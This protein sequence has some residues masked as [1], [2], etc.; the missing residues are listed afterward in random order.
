MRVSRAD[1]VRVGM[2]LYSSMIF[3]GLLRDGV[4]PAMARKV[5]VTVRTT[6]GAAVRMRLVSTN[7]ALAVPLPK[8]TRYRPRVFTPAEVN[9]FLAAAASDR[10]DALYLL[11][12]DS[13]CRQSEL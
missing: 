12:I 10:F 6:L 8:V 2:R 3:S 5:G 9:A 1:W 11:A 13:G 4:S 7:V